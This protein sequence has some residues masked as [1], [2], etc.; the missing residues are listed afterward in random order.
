MC[1]ERWDQVKNP[2]DYF[3]ARMWGESIV[4]VRDK[5]NQLH[6]L[7]NVCQHRWSQVVEDGAGNAK[8][9]ICPYHRWT[10]NL[11]GTLRGISVQ[12]MPEVDRKKCR[13]PSLR[14]EDWQGFIMI[15]FD[16]EAEPLAPQL[17]AI[18]DS[19]SPPA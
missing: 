16:P 9:F 1:V 19:R 17:E 7:V 6:A 18:N 12:N 3:T 15:N 14:I 4:I 8:A 5:K 2:G 13:L 10:Y 11:D